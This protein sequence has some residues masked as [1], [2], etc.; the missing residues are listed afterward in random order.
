ML[1]LLNGFTE[2][3]AFD[4]LRHHSQSLNIKLADVARTVIENRGQLPP[5]ALETD[6]TANP[7][8]SG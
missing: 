4:L 8:V 2:E 3:E 1:M 6:D 5:E 7:T